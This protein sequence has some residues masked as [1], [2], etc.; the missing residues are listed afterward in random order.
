MFNG[1]LYMWND[2]LLD[3]ELKDDVKPVCSRPYT[4]LK[5]H[6]VISK[7]EVKGLVSLGSPKHENESKWGSL[8]F[9][10]PKEK[11]NN[12]EFLIGFRNLNGK[13]KHKPYHMPKY[14]KY[15]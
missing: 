3:L 11:M 5:V 7:K 9:S 13:L 10:Q 15:Y 14:R 6:K 12:V 4:L 1:T 8:S 2:K